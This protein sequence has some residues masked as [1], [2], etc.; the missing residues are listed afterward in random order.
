MIGPRH[1]VSSHARCRPRRAG[2]I[3]T[4][5]GPRTAGGLSERFFFTHSNFG[6]LI[7]F[8]DARKDCEINDEWRR[9]R[10]RLPIYFRTPADAGAWPDP[11]GGGGIKSLQP[12]GAS[13]AKGPRTQNI[14]RGEPLIQSKGN[15]T[16][17]TPFWNY[18]CYA[19]RHGRWDQKYSS[20]I[21]R[22]VAN[23]AN[24]FGGFRW[25][26]AARRAVAFQRL[27]SARNLSRNS[28]GGGSVDSG[29]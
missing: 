29:T 17:Q 1:Q 28:P 19:P 26:A 24:P 11:L 27:P 21:G 10:A 6:G 2:Q 15:Q 22:S 12:S 18:G 3:S 4:T 20:S 8:G 9:A 16:N 25:T 7:S 5:L 13:T 14:S 23:G